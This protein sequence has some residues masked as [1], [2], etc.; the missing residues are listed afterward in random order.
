MY[1]S[2][3][4]Y[5]ASVKPALDVAF[6]E[7]LGRLLGH[8]SPCHPDTLQG[9][10]NGKKIRGTLLCLVAMALGVTLQDALPRAV[11]VEL[12]QT[13]TLIH[14]DFVDGHRMRRGRP[15]LWTLEDPRRAVLL[16]DVIF[17]SAIELASQL[18]LQDCR[19][20]SR[21]I[22]RLA[23]GAWYE[24]LDG[25]A[26][27]RASD[28]C[29]E[30]GVDYEQII[31]LKTGEL[32]AA[33]C[34]LGAVAAGAGEAA[35]RQWHRYGLK[36]GEA[37][38]LADDLHDI[39]RVLDKGKL[40]IAEFADL[41]PALSYFFPEIRDDIVDALCGKGPPTKDLLPWLERVTGVMKRD[42]QRRLRAAVAELDVIARDGPLMRLVRRAP[43]DLVG[44]FD[45]KH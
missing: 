10:T 26:L 1:A 6:C 15:A 13:A 16:G 17:S 36:I 40:S 24:P 25:T 11:A 39:E 20:A 30:G 33:A 2:F 5:A 41:A 29:P 44:M 9:L 21:V 28:R 27:L 3:P 18:S 31:V 32:F 7:E 37:Y 14:D 45:G 42:R 22:A 35:R 19:I 23:R 43:F 8:C 4:E 12:I 34:E 38:Q